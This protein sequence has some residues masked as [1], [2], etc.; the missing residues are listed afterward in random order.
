M[1]V[2]V[3]C[4]TREIGRVNQMTWD[5]DVRVVI[6]NGNA[7]DGDLE[8]KVGAMAVD[9]VAATESV[10]RC[11]KPY[12][13]AGL[14]VEVLAEAP[15]PQPDLPDLKRPASDPELPPGYHTEQNGAW[16]LAIYNGTKVGKAQRSRDQAQQTAWDH[17]LEVTDG[18]ND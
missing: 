6:R 7:F 11:L 5:D 14:E 13:E 4:K 10:M 2:L 18:G 12:R 1:L 16:W 3:Y 15:V 9:K 8:F 17:Y